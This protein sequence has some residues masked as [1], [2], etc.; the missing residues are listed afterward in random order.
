MSVSTIISSIARYEKELLKLE[1]AMADEL[2]KE[3]DK[4]KKISV[5]SLLK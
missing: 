2:K 3:A 4:K 1:K 5:A